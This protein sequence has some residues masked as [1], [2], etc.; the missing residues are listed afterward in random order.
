MTDQKDPAFPGS[1]SEPEPDLAPSAEPSNETPDEAI[2]ESTAVDGIE[3]VPS[4]A[5]GDTPSV[6]AE[7]GAT[8]S[9]AAEA[10]AAAAAG[11]SRSST[12][13][14]GRWS[15]P[16]LAVAIL[17]VVAIV[18]AAGFFAGLG[19]LNKLST[20]RSLHPPNQLGGLGRI[21]DQETRTRLE[22]DKINDTV[23]QTN[24]GH[25]TVVDAYGDVTGGAGLFIV[26]G[27][28]GK[29]DIDK[30]VADSVDG[31]A[32]AG[33]VSKVGKSTCATTPNDGVVTC[34]RG[35]NTLTV[36]VRDG[37]GKAPA[38]KVGAMTDEAFDAFN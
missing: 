2:V 29:I 38:N 22:L 4:D 19:P 20:K 28:R 12:K 18:A 15:V 34:Y 24:E 23:A 31:A 14:A 13:P 30:T 33:Q 7:S 27:L 3:P 25:R 6:S 36:M 8:E 9:G 17:V 10:G 21:T 16:T 5:A 37:T 32:G 35:S 26:I 1:P 11:S